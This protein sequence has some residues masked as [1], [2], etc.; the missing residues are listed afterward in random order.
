MDC[1]CKCFWCFAVSQCWRTQ[2]RFTAITLISHTLQNKIF[3]SVLKY[4]SP[5]SWTKAI[6]LKLL[7][8]FAFGILTVPQAKPERLNANSHMPCRAPTV[9]WPCRLGSDFSRPRYGMAW[10]V[11]INNGLWAT[12]PASVSSGYHAE[13]HEGSFHSAYPL[14][15]E[16][17]LRSTKRETHHNWWEVHCFCAR[18]RYWSNIFKM[19]VRFPYTYDFLVSIS[20]GTVK[21]CDCD[22]ASVFSVTLSSTLRSFLRLLCN[23]SAAEIILS[24]FAGLSRIRPQNNLH[25]W[26]E[27]ILNNPACPWEF[28]VVNFLALIIPGWNS[29]VRS[30]QI[31]L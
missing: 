8:H 12:C 9:L 31:P 19:S 15:T 22:G 20:S 21:C 26:A 13:L 16:L 24:V 6:N 28:V 17:Q 4:F 2:K 14:Q 3:P 10:H 5:N 29:R 18:T 1:K 23:T 27:S 7:V 30:E 11:W 25:F